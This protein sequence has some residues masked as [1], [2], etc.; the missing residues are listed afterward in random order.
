VL[1]R[2]RLGGSWFEANLGE[3]EFMRPRANKKKLS[4]THT[5]HPSY[6]GRVK[7]SIIIQASLDINTR[8]YSK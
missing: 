2:L 4:V 6:T 5:C 1:S 3:K 7:R 8:P